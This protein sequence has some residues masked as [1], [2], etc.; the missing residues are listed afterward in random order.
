MVIVKSKIERI[1]AF[2]MLDA[3]VALSIITILIVLSTMTF[4]NLFTAQKP[5]I[6]FS[7]EIEV[8]ERLN[9]LKEN[10][11][12]KNN[13]YEFENFTINQNVEKYENNSKLYHVLYEAY[14]LNS[15]L[16]FSSNHL[17]AK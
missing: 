6:K 13:Q 12:M 16:I 1:D 4:S 8:I 9:A 17:I 5:L 7:A 3:I 15:K 10:G 14:D 11:V 2:T